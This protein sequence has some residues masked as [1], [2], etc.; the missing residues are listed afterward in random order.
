MKYAEVLIPQKVGDDSST[1]TY[2]SIP[3]A[4]I[5]HAVK[6]PLRNRESHGI[7]L[8]IHSKKPPFKTLPIKEILYEKP[9]LSA[10]QLELMQWMSEFYFCPLFKILKLFVP[11]RILQGKPVKARKKEAEQIIR[12][13]P[14]ELTEQQ[15]KIVD[16]IKSSK[17]NKFL[18]HGVT[19][20]G[21][22]EVYTRLSEHFT[23]KG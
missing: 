9:L 17:L 1:L 18:I 2:Q 15:K 12:S 13:Q 19:G 8:K 21:K 4:E 22:T 7:I 6:I 11:T 16:H 10:T 3:K 23:K 14:K 5:G 20:S